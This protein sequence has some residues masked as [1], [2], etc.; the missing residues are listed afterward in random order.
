MTNLF[1]FRPVVLDIA[2][3]TLN[4]EDIQR[5]T[6]QLTGGVILFAR[7]FASRKQLQSLTQQIKFHA[8]HVIIFIDHE[9]G[10]VQRCKTDGFTH[11]PAMAALGKLYLQNPWYALQSAKA[12][13]YILAS[14]LRA[15]GVDFS[16]TPILDLDYENSSVIG[17]RAFAK[18]AHIVAALAQNLMF[19]LKQ[20]GM[21]NCGKHFPGHGFVVADSHI[22]IPI[23]ERE[24][25]QIWQ[26]DILPY[27]LLIQS[28]DSIM[29]AHVIYNKI[30]K[31]PAGFSKFWLQDILRKKLGFNGIIFS[32]DLAME[33]ASVAGNV[34]QG[35][36]AA[37]NAGC[38]MVLICNKPNMADELLSGLKYAQEYAQKSLTRLDKITPKKFD[39]SWEELQNSEI[40]TK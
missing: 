21:S 2:G 30:D 37:L 26:Q 20:A 36:E 27:M 1:S 38:D 28:L 17:D 22:D 32:D 23:D 35:A 11:L 5:L 34:V 31:N 6:H 33:G 18:D 19:G 15:C 10:R 8:P 13:G 24:F 29:P 39:L 4:Q 16:Y 40:Y 25:E 12:C 9:G 3:L 14:E 7:N